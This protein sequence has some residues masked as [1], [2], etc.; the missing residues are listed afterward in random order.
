MSAEY[1][2]WV[3][4]DSRRIAWRM[5]DPAPD[6]PP[7]DIV[8]L[9]SLK[10]LAA[11]RRR[12]RALLTASLSERGMADPDLVEEVVER[13]ILVIDELASNAIRHGTAPAT[14]DVRDTGDHW[15][16]VATDAAPHQ[17]PTPARDRPEGQGGYG[18]Y[19]IADLASAHGVEVDGARKRVW[20]RL[21]KY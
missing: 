18:L 13:S 21:P 10:Q 2:P 20:A 9:I 12:V 4:G 19:V 1:E 5:R 14:L 15:V 6:I 11:V 16:V 3:E 8:E 17:L 7:D